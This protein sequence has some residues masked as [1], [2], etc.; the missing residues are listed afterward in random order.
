MSSRSGG[1]TGVLVALV[2]FVVLTVGLLATS[3]VLYAGKSD[4]ETRES[5]AR[6]DLNTF[7]TEGERNRP[8]TQSLKQSA[9]GNSLF[10]YLTEQAAKTG[11]FVAN[12]RSADLG[13]MRTA[14]ALG[15][16]DTVK[17]SM[18]KL[19]QERDARSQEATALKQRSVDLGK[20]IDT[21]KSQLAAAEKT[22]EEAIAKITGSISSYRDA[23]N[24]YRGEFDDAKKSLDQS[25]ADMQARFASETSTLQ[26]EIDTLRSERSVLDGRIAALQKKVNASSAKAGNPA[27]LVDAHVVDFDPKNG[28]VFID[29]G[30][31]RR[32]V[33]GMTFEVFDDAA[34]ITASAQSGNR[35]KASIQV[36]KVGDTTSTCRIIRGSGSRPIVKD[37]VAAN[38]VFNPDYKFKFLVHGKFDINGDGKA[39]TGEADFIKSR[40]KEWG[41]EVADG[42]KLT[43]DL[44]FLVLGVQ[45]PMPTPLGSDATEAQTL[46]YTEQRNTR[47]LYDGLFRTAADAE[48]PVLNWTRFETLTGTVNR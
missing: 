28:T 8:E 12:D 29:I 9:G 39:T 1:S 46:A 14:L 34:G 41:G 37:D 4:A 24:G 17:E 42:D 40:I 3:I 35:G 15:E 23:A 16:T 21:L 6:A 10:S 26:S 18:R 45:P 33:P 2:V 44:D 48:I 19:Q 20:E 11:E 31:N 7:I 22:R 27:A 36:V 25:R 32:V 30:S 5:Q 43:G 47:E 13:R 38:A